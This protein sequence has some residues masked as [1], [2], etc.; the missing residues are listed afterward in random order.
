MT[1]E[2]Q[3]QLSKLLSLILRHQ[4]EKF[5]LA[6][7]KDGELPL[8]NLLAALREQRQWQGVTEA[9]IRTVVETSDKQR[10]EII[11][12]TIRA[13]YGH[14]VRQPVAYPPVEP[15]AHLYH[16]TSPHSL[17]AIRAQGL[18]PMRRQYVHLSTESEQA[19]A[20]GR[21]H[22]PRPVILTIRAFE[23]W[24]AEVRFYCPE[25]RL[26]LADQVP[27]QFIDFWNEEE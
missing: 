18:R 16:G 4:P 2:N 9:E 12:D 13:R 25:A 10:F 3:K 21:R 27:P 7:G 5:G 8:D 6:L 15:P 19:R 22:H 11:G 20:V 1:A 23:A 14:S 17:P 26:Y 24:S